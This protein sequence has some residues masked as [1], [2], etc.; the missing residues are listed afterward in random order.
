MNTKS[1][2]PTTRG[3]YE[4]AHIIPNGLIY[5]G[6]SGQQPRIRWKPSN[7]KK[8]S[9]Q[10]YI[11]EFGWNNIQHVVLVDGLTED[12]ALKLEGL[13]IEEAK[14][15]GWCINKN[16]SGGIRRDNTK[17]YECK[18]SRKRRQTEEYKAYQREYQCERYQSEEYKEWNRNYKREYMRQ[19]RLKKKQ[20]T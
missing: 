14:K 2:Y 9:L 4:Y 10:P 18:R 8:C 19:Y 15:G 6:R 12:Q 11:E 17:E 7:Y 16:D 1:K 13:L 3:H 5:I 20:S